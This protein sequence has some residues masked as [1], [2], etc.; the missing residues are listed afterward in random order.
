MSKLRLPQDNI[1]RAKGLL[2]LLKTADKPS[3]DVIELKLEKES[4]HELVGLVELLAGEDDLSPADAGKLA[5]VSRPVIMHLLE[6]GMLKGYPV[7]SQWRIKR[8][9]VLK[10][11]EDR[12]KFAKVMQN[13][14]EQGFGIPLSQG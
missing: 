14:D 13:M 8:D 5:R 2:A 10:Y 11:L 4:F 9:S 6:T 12:E 3:A 1:D 7:K